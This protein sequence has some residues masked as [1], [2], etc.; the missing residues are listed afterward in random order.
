MVP[1]CAHKLLGHLFIDLKGKSIESSFKEIE[2][3][4]VSIEILSF[5]EIFLKFKRKSN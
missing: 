1:Y 4:L 2:N 3:K 5:Q